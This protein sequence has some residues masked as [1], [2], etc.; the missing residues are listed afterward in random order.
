[1]NSASAQSG[2][3]SF[4]GLLSFFAEQTI[5]A[6]K[7]KIKN[8]EKALDTEGNEYLIDLKESLLGIRTAIYYQSIKTK[9]REHLAVII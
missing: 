1:M 9:H 7:I 3:L 6:L 8:K 5:I 2:K 4:V